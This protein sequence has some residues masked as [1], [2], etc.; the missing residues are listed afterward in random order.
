[1]TTDTWRALRRERRRKICRG[2]WRTFI[3]TLGLS[4]AVAFVAHL[5]WFRYG[6][7]ELPLRCLDDD[8]WRELPGELT[9][10]GA[11][12][13]EAILKALYGDAAVKR[14]SIGS[15]L[16]RP[17]VVNFD[18]NRRLVE[19][20]TLLTGKFAA[21]MGSPYRGQAWAQDCRVTQYYLL[22]SRHAEACED[23]WRPHIYGV[24]GQGSWPWLT[25]FFRVQQP[26]PHFFDSLPVEVM[27]HP[28]DRPAHLAGP[29][30]SGDIVC[31]PSFHD[32]MFFGAIFAVGSVMWFAK[33]LWPF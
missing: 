18:D 3:C 23:P 24:I 6:W 2:V 12:S 31:G 14:T 11:A 8:G 21:A 20:T 13:Y 30:V 15:I 10:Q 26:G 19:L 7:T 16:V 27:P 5:T 29:A 33:S 4:L 32:R 9:P 28:A 1:M 17:A 22:T 25:H